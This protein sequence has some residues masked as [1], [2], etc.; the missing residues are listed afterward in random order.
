MKLAIETLEWAHQKTQI[1]HLVGWR[2]KPVESSI[3]QAQ[4]VV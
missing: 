3:V 4:L 1:A 2:A